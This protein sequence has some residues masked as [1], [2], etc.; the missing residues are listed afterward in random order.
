MTGRDYGWEVR[1]PG[2]DGRLDTP[3]DRLGTSRL[4]IPAKTSVRVELESEDY[5]YTVAL[6]HFD[7]NE[8]VVP[9]MEFELRLPPS[10]DGRFDLVGD[11]LCGYDHPELLGV[12]IVRTQE[13][14][15]QWL[16]GAATQE[17]ETLNHAAS[18]SN[19]R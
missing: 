12:L 7:L 18:R 8:V 5:V 10:E 16:A 2:P 3:D 15:E 4:N 6:P 13:D 9:D 1:H 14:Y 19:T 11:H 17:E